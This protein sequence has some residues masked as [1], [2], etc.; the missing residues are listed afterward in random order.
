MTDPASPAA[1]TEEL[2][3]EQIDAARAVLMAQTTDKQDD[4]KAV[5][6]SPIVADAVKAVALHRRCLAAE[7]ALDARGL[8]LARL[9]AQRHDV[10]NDNLRLEEA[11]A[12]AEA[13]LAQRDEE[14]ARLKDELGELRLLKR[15]PLTP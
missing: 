1:V 7:A 11:L 8:E 6:W 2:A 9:T 13:A 4:A 14:V 12:A 10:V 15:D 5:T 3:L